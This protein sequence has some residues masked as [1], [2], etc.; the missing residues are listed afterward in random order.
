M[1][2]ALTCQLT[3]LSNIIKP[4]KKDNNK[5]LILT[6]RNKLAQLTTKLNRIKALD[7]D[8]NWAMLGETGSTHY[9]RSAQAKRH[10]AWVR[11]LQI[12]S[13]SEHSKPEIIFN[14]IEIEDFFFLYY[15]GRPLL[16]P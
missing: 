10:E 1:K 16:S 12:P 8:V 15:Q 7:L 5:K 4:Y 11:Q 3:T 13:P 9:F 14:S 2:N 6:I